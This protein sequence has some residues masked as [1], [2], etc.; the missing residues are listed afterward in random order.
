MCVGTIIFTKTLDGFY[1]FLSHENFVLAFPFFSKNMET[2]KRNFI[3]QEKNKSHQKQQ[4]KRYFDCDSRLVI[5]F[6][7]QMYPRLFL[8]R[9]VPSRAVSLILCSAMN[10]NS[11]STG[12]YFDST[13]K[14]LHYNIVWKTKYQHQVQTFFALVVL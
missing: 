1:F 6:S 8:I 2:P 12:N 14:K 3:A 4:N 5:L 7:G 10:T 13:I 11:I 9:S